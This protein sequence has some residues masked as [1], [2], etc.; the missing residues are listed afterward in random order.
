MNEEQKEFLKACQEHPEIV[1]SRGV[2]KL[3]EIVRELG[4]HIQ[5]LEFK[6][7]IQLAKIELKRTTNYYE[8]RRII[9]G[10][11]LTLFLTLTIFGYWLIFVP[12]S[13]EPDQAM[14]MKVEQCEMKLKNIREVINGK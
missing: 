2:L 3:A 12:P 6:R 14:Q 13:I 11:F 5:N 4:T 8:R 7:D 1:D 9:A 10:A